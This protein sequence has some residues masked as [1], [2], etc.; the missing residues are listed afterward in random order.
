MERRRFKQSQTLKQRLV[1]E[2]GR[3]RDEARLLPPGRRREMLLR[4]VRQDET[5][6]QIDAWLSS[7]GLRAPT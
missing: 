4:R 2:V 5:A 7:P 1:N 6:I 3:L